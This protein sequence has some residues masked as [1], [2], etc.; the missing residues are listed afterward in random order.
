MLRFFPFGRQWCTRKALRLEFRRS[1]WARQLAQR[2]LSLERLEPRH[3]LSA[4]PTGLDLFAAEAEAGLVGTASVA[5]PPVASFDELSASLGLTGMLGGSGEFHAGGLTFTDLTNDGY[6]DL[7]L[8]G[9]SS[10]GNRLYVNVDDGVGGRTFVRV[11]GDG[12]AA[13]TLGNSTGAVAADFDNDGDLDLY[14]TNFRSNNRLF[15]NM[16]IEDHPDGTGDPLTLRFVDV[17]SLT[18]PTPSNPI[19]DTQHGVGFATFQNP[20]PAFGNDVLRSSLA[21]AWADVNRDGWIDLFVGSWD[22]TNGDPSTAIDGQ[23]GERDTLYLNNGDGTFTDI[24]M[25]S[26]PRPDVT[27]ILSDGSFEQAT[28]NSQI[29]NSGWVMTTNAPGGVQSAQFQQAPWAASDLAIGVWFKSFPGRVGDTADAEVRQVVTVPEN[30]DYTLRFDA[31][32]EENFN[33]DAFRVTIT[34]AG[35]GGTHTIELLDVVTNTQFNTYL[36]SL[37]G[38]TAGDQLTIV[39]EMIGGAVPAAGPQQ[40]AMVDNF[41]LLSS[42]DAQSDHRSPLGGWENADGSFNDPSLPAEFSGQNSLQFADFNND[43]WQDLVIATMGGGSVGPNRDMLYIN[44][45]NDEAGQWLGYRLV[46][47]DIGFG[48]NESSDMGVTVADVDNDG[49]LDYFSTILPTAHPL[50]INNFVETGTLSFTQTTIDNDFSWG[51]NFHDFDNNGRVD[52]LVGTDVAR[53]SSS[54]TSYLHMQTWSGEFVEQGAAAGFTSPFSIR[55]VA[56]AD[57]DRDGW[58]DVA[59]WTQPELNSPGIQFYRNESAAEN[60]EFHF[61][62]LELEGD[63]T[64]PGLLKSTRDAIGARPYVT[65][66]FNGDGVIGTDETRMEEVLSGHSNASTTSSLALEF[67][68]GLANS[69]DVV[70]RWGSGREMR[71]EGVAGDQFLRVKEQATNIDLLLGDYNRDGSVDAADF[72][73]WRDTLG[74]TTTSFSA[75]DGNGNGVIDQGDYAAWRANFGTSRP[76]LQTVELS[77]AGVETVDYPAPAVVVVD[78]VLF[79]TALDEPLYAA[80]HV[81]DVR[82]RMALDGSTLATIHARSSVQQHTPRGVAVSSRVIEASH[83]DPLLLVAE[84]VV[85]DSKQRLRGVGDAE[86]FG[87]SGDAP[88]RESQRMAIDLALEDIYQPVE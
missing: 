27:A 74:T 76:S 46:S 43:G 80:A 63:P 3:V 58:S 11:P 4:S 87:L 77:F 38:V 78:A 75:A 73:V 5:V 16:W 85:R 69:A 70:I 30:G 45:G 33:A 13:Y 17:T 21:A 67:G 68:L 72:T 88:Q 49:D 42:N 31:R 12:G 24:T 6:A 65:A 79:D 32:I 86:K 9:P 48:G 51:A 23:L 50:W 7:Y 47:F 25:I 1:T 34:S 53:R 35:T 84:S 26:T 19:G 40:S 52:L 66:D 37:A 20:D 83:S 14:L 22:G 29:S 59:Q 2:A 64:L 61:L 28:P 39:A 62:T 15:K 56:V 41:V 60:S 18:D 44:R 10:R 82:A 57:F 81:S 71:L 8:I 54:P 36:L 55:G